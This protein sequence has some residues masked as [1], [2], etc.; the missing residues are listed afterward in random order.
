[1][2]QG[3]RRKSANRRKQQRTGAAYTSVNA[4]TTHR[5][6]APDDLGPVLTGLPYAA[7]SSVDTALALATIAACRAG[8][9]P[10]QASLIPRALQDRALVSVLAGSVRSSPPPPGPGCRSRG[11]PTPVRRG[12]PRSRPS[13]R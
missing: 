13:R 4:G 7:G 1:M 2:P 11:R 8:C 12:R 9:S 10:C 6:P 3:S 5:H